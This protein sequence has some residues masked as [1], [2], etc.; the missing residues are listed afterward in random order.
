MLSKEHQ[1]H[2]SLLFMRLLT[3]ATETYDGENSPDVAQLI[4]QELKD[5]RSPKALGV[6]L[7]MAVSLVA[8]DRVLFFGKETTESLNQELGLTVAKLDV[9]G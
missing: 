6:A 8:V 5:E 2:G 7:A 1:E 4:L 9:N 3:L